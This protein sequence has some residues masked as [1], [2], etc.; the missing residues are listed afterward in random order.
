MVSVV[1]IVQ[2][3]CRPAWWLARFASGVAAITAAS[4]VLPPEA[5]QAHDEICDGGHPIKVSVKALPPKPIHVD[6]DK[7][8]AEVTRLSDETGE[9]TA[10]HKGPALGLYRAKAGFTYS[11]KADGRGLATGGVCVALKAIDIQFG[12]TA[13]QILVAREVRDKPCIQAFVLMHEERH[14]AADQSILSLYLTH[15]QAALTLELSDGLTVGG[16]TPDEARGLLKQTLDERLQR[17]I[18]EFS[19]LRARAQSRVHE[20]DQ[21]QALE[22]ACGAAARESLD[23]AK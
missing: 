14:V 7:T 2:V 8:I 20:A 1:G 12:I 11:V 22:N 23:L 3:R 16:T 18:R 6:L 21:A 9:R 17:A 10:D 15:L 13:R 5:A 4:L 19:A